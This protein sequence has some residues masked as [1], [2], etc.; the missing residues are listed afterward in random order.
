MRSIGRQADDADRRLRGGGP[1]RVRVTTRPSDFAQT[2][3]E[4]LEPFL[5]TL[6][7][8]LAGAYPA[9]GVAFICGAPRDASRT[10]GALVRARAALEARGGS[11]IVEALPDSVAE[12]FATLDTWGTPPQSFGL[13]RA[14]KARFD[15]QAR[16]NPGCFVGGL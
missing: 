5:Q 1:L 8:A 11:L 13:M 3:L 12:G 9:L 4:T 10:L 14:L 2:D 6:D 7:G 16:L 15:P